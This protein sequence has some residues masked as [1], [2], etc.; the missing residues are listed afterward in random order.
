M[1][2]LNLFAITQAILIFIILL[3]NNNKHSTILAY[4]IIIPAYSFIG[5]ILNL[6]GING[7]LFYFIFTSAQYINMFFSILVLYYIYMMCGQKLKITNK[8]L[9]LSIPAFV[10]AIYITYEFLIFSP[11][12]RV[13]YIAKLKDN[14]F[15]L[16]ALLCNIFFV[17]TQ[18]VYFTLC[19]IKTKRF[20]KIVANTF[21]NKNNTQIKFTSLII[22]LFWLLNL[23][24]L[25]CYAVLP[26]NIA[27]Y[28]ILPILYLIVCY[29]IIFYGFKEQ[30]IFNKNSYK[31]Y[32]KDIKHTLNTR[33]STKKE[34]LILRQEY[35][36]V[37]EEFMTTHKSYKQNDLTIHSLSRELEISQY[38]LSTIINQHYNQNF[39]TWI[40]NYRILEAKKLLISKKDAF[41]LEGIA[42]EVGFS[43]RISFYRQFKKITGQTPS[44]Y[45]V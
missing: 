24:L 2:E 45:K 37:I 11:R 23:V 39:N 28:V 36:G 44:E 14:E 31:H 13:E 19:S 4:L 38:K 42:I 26:T 35:I 40:N 3:I 10:M 30:A 1:I 21:A 7:V 5:N 18:F 8:V 41:S 32:L 9:A 6:A 34:E 29:C 20:K 43:N 17:T 27:E 25:I 22:N 12:Q 16:S 15:P 33:L